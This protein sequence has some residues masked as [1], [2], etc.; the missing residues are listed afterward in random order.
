MKLDLVDIKILKKLEQNADKKLSEIGKKAGLFSASATSRRLKV[1]RENKIIKRYT[2][3][4]DLD[5]L[6]FNFI[7][8]TLVRAKYGE[9]YINN[10]AAQIMGIQGVISIY[11]LLGDIDFV[12]LTA[13]RDKDDYTHILQQLTK[14]VEIE[15]TD[16]RTVLKIF[17]ENDFS[18]VLDLLQGWY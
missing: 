17:K 4:L 13:S 2:I 7:T 8:L 18:S 6:G 3:S 5:K 9:N 16:S 11:F 10:V 1:L 14:I 12:L 15:R